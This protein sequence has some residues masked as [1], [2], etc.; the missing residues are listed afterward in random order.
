MPLPLLSLAPAALGP[1]ALP[2][3]PPA[4]RPNIILFLVDDMGWQD[5]SVPFWR[6][7]TP[8][9]A[10]YRTPNM[11]RLARRGVKFTEAY[12]CPVSSPSR[13]SLITGMAAARHRVTNWT[14][15]YAT[16]TDLP[17]GS[18][19]LPPWHCNGIRPEGR[20]APRDTLLST[21]ATP[22]PQ[23]LRGLGYRTILCGK[24]HFAALGTSGADPRTLGFDVSIAG[25]AIGGPASYLGERGYGTGTFHV[26][27]LERYEGTDTFLT[28]ALTREALAAVEAPVAAG[29]PFFLY[30]SHYAIHVPYDEDR[31][32][33]PAYRTPD[34][35]GRYDAQLD[36]P[37]SEAE[38]RRA[39]LVE[40]MDKSLGDVL[41]FLDARPDVARRTVIVFVSDNGG[42]AIS[43][44]QGR[45]DRDP[46]APARGGKGSAHL[47]GVRVPM[48]VAWPGVAP[49]GTE[50]RSRVMIEDLFPTLLDMAGAGRVRTLQH[51]DGRSIVPLVRDPSLL[52]PRPI[53]WH[54][55]NRWD[56]STDTAEGYG[57]FSALLDGPYHLL[58]FWEPREL[59][60]YDVG[61]DVGE[62]ADLAPTRP[63]LLKKLARQLTDSLRAQG[64]QRPLDAATGRPVPW[65]D[66]STEP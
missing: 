53:V 36:A 66:G 31:R 28:E 26:P 8:L 12:A 29:Q 59:R 64:A 3:T 17:G 24:A 2:A 35:R 33:S 50:S 55:P 21:P 57:A 14:L 20:A 23:L 42:H 16:P 60:L 44:R 32:F 58:Y 61:A 49:G 47:G 5:T 11:E 25:S 48:I 10:R 43:P 7:P 15:R 62:Q 56:G 22:L 1:A 9:N 51:V 52:R 38:V 46:N 4:G 63:D 65:P 13:A 27:G 40:G 45:H 30:L 18:L 19:V 6:E 34:G 41:A 37:L 39:A 54:F